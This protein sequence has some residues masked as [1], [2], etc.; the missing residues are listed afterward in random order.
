MAMSTFTPSSREAHDASSGWSLHDDTLP[1]ATLSC[2][3]GA[4]LLREGARA[5]GST[6]ARERDSDPVPPPM[7]P[8]SR[9]A[10]LVMPNP[11]GAAVA[12]RAAPATQAAAA[13]PK[14]VAASAARRR[15][16]RSRRADTHSRAPSLPWRPVG[17]FALGATVAALAG[18]GVE[19]GALEV[20]ALASAVAGGVTLAAALTP[21]LSQ[22][23]TVP[24][25]QW[26]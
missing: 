6:F 14:T 20:A 9:R 13:I 17:A 1:G 25:R 23:R 24:R 8:S 11:S 7:T 5:V 3:T 19:R 22:R 15:P 21:A 18:L 2:L 4:I 12:T 10:L 16:S 26:Q